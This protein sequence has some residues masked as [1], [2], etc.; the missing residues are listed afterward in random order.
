[1]DNFR[2]LYRLK[3]EHDYFGQNMCRSMRI[4]IDRA[5]LDLMKRRGI[6]FKQTA[7]NEWSIIGKQSNAGTNITSEVLTLQMN[8]SD[9]AFVL[10]T[11]W[12]D[13]H[14]T[15]LY[16]L[17]LPATT[18][19]AVAAIRKTDEKRRINSG[20]CIIDLQFTE[21]M[22][23]SMCEGNLITDTLTFYSKEVQW[24]YLFIPRNEEEN[25]GKKLILKEFDDKICFSASEEV[26]IYEKKAWRF[27]SE[28]KIKIQE[29]YNF[30]ISLQEIIP[31][32]LQ[33]QKKLIKNIPHPVSGNFVN[34][35]P[36]VLRHICYF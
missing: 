28:E 14:P 8:I 11:D 18:T 25:V 24:E 34:E 29:Y 20:F 4:S 1:M 33:T 13:F 10:Y 2:A 3:I 15:S 35:Q 5:G 9:P 6:L 36:H 26:E 19:D 32:R 30:C 23:R 17:S 16:R 12:D 7:T 27:L 31:N 21:N 22:F